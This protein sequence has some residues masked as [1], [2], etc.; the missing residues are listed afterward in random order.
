M[1]INFQF[2]LVLNYAHTHILPKMCTLDSR[3]RRFIRKRNDKFY[4]SKFVFFYFKV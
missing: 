3:L 2:N 1:R 4:F